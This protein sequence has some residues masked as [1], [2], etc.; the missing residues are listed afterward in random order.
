MIHY[1][2]G[3]REQL[4]PFSEARRLNNAEWHKRPPNKQTQSR[5]VQLDCDLFIVITS[6]LPHGAICNLMRTCRALSTNE[7]LRKVLWKAP[8]RGKEFD[9]ES[10][11]PPS[12]TW[13][14]FQ[15]FWETLI[16]GHKGYPKFIRTIVLPASCA[17]LRLGD[18]F[19][20]CPN[21]VG[22][23]ISELEVGMDFDGQ[24]NRCACRSYGTL[25]RHKIWCPADRV[26]TWDMLMYAH[27]P[28][29]EYLTY[30]R[31]PLSHFW[32][33]KNGFPFVMMPKV[34]LSRFLEACTSLETLALYGGKNP[35]AATQTVVGS[36]IL[37]RVPKR[38]QVLKL[39]NTGRTILSLGVFVRR[40]ER[41][42][43]LRTI[44][45]TFDKD[46][47][48]IVESGMDTAYYNPYD[49]SEEQIEQIQ[50]GF[51]DET[52]RTLENESYQTLLTT[53][54]RPRTIWEFVS[55]LQGIENGGCKLHSLNY[56]HP[57]YCD[58]LKLYDAIIDERARDGLKYL[59]ELIGF[60]VVFDLYLINRGLKI[61]EGERNFQEYLA[62]RYDQKRKLEFMFPEEEMAAN[63]MVEL[64]FQRLH[65]LGFPVRVE[66]NT[67]FRVGWKSQHIFF[68]R[69]GPLTY[70]RTRLDFHDFGVWITDLRINY[71]AK[72]RP[73]ERMNGQESLLK[74][75]EEE[76]EEV[77]AAGLRLDLIPRLGQFP[78]L[79]RLE[80]CLRPKVH[81]NSDFHKVDMYLGAEWKMRQD[82]DTYDKENLTRMLN[83][84]WNKVGA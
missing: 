24:R 82:A 62:G 26:C 15:S 76:P 52:P 48:T 75:L 14:Q 45:S 49:V 50:E 64:M 69:E 21:L 20:H 19:T 18:I 10:M 54:W 13:K 23:E 79:T 46:I 67:G 6:Q 28:M 33:E 51:I 80:I 66:L 25:S 36:S 74:E 59:V 41:C 34:G 81:S 3:L 27:Q 22:L 77:E 4:D 38:L 16:R 65:W 56:G 30:L 84:V 2:P 32:T 17:M 44:Y 58:P 78:R 83:F 70:P 12:R 11:D 63:K 55:H 68:H 5:L 53:Q 29:F 40:I 35:H 57:T 7:F 73:I 42:K 31:Y 39:E 43:A 60:K 8:F 37:E 9:D 61:A 72:G 47:E 1:A 71:C